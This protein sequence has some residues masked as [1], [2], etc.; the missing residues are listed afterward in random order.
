MVER[1]KDYKN[2]SDKPQ[3]DVFGTPMPVKTPINFAERMDAQK[4]TNKEAMKKLFLV[5][6]V[7][8]FFITA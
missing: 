3:L 2:L 6:F 5:S 1:N 4:K 8:V 7:S